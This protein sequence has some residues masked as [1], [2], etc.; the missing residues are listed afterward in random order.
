MG[1]A[2]LGLALAGSDAIS[3]R[4]LEQSDICR[5]QATVISSERVRLPM[6]DAN[7]LVL[8]DLSWGPD[9]RSACGLLPAH[10]MLLMPASVLHD[11][12]LVGRVVVAYL[13]PET[14][15]APPEERLPDAVRLRGDPFSAMYVE[16]DGGILSLTG[17][18]VIGFDCGTGPEVLQTY[19]RGQPDHRDLT[20]AGLLQQLQVCAT[21]GVGAPPVPPPYPED[22]TYGPPRG[23]GN[24]HDPVEV[25]RNGRYRPMAEYPPIHSDP[26]GRAMSVVG[27]SPR[28]VRV[29]AD[30]TWVRLSGV[31]TAGVYDGPTVLALP[32]RP[33]ER[34]F[35]PTQDFEEIVRRVR[36][37]AARP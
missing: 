9:D 36:E 7:R 37:A 13:S 29:M 35:P 2:L 25:R 26:W 5:V 27:L 10:P 30:G 24:R 21:D 11:V 23:P 14:S 17:H 28:Y 33:E 34:S 32:P 19:P 6:H 8:G 16:V 15:D 22:R 4:S 1:L 3:P 20:L 12:E 31:D 18:R